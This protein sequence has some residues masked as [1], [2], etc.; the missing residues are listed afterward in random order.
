[1]RDA[2]VEHAVADLEAR[3]V[4][5]AA[6]AAGPAEAQLPVAEQRRLVELE[7]RRGPLLGVR[8]ALGPVAEG[9]DLQLAALAELDVP[10]TA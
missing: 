6:G 1:M 10:N 5:L 3:A 4:D 8:G 9:G 7:L 2:A